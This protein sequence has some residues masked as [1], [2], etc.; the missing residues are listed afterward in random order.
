MGR[1]ALEPAERAALARLLER[2]K[3]EVLPLASLEPELVHVQPG[4]TLT[5]TSSPSKGIEASVAL[6]ERLRAA[7]FGVVIHLAARMVRDGA[8]LRELLDRLGA[9]GVDRAFVVGGDAAPAG[10]FPDGIALLRRMADDG[11]PFREIGVPGYPQGHPRVPDHHLLA[12]L[13]AKAAFADYVTTQICFD[14]AATRRWV[15]E[16]RGEGLTL[17][18]HLGIPGAVEIARLL[19]VSARIGVADAGRFVSRHAGLLGRFL[20]PGGYEP[21]SLLEA[22]A[23]AVADASADVQG[24]HVYTFNQLGRTERWR[25]RYLARL[26]SAG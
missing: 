22:L 5:V 16:R 1:Q 15:A 25:Q 17:P 2:P 10:D 7:Q 13:A 18:V 12:D 9:A 19:R 6:A 3:L 21:T 20:R 26:A 14:A 4:T 24:L 11:H 8:H 23:P